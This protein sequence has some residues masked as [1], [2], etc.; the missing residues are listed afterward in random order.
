MTLII[1]T[2]YCWFSSKLR[3]RA[4]E[5]RQN[6]NHKLL[7]LFAFSASLSLCLQPS[8]RLYTTLRAAL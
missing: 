2:G 4:H 1:V 8:R 6:D 7:V 3:T 5:N